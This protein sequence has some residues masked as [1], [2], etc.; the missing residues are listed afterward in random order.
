M[1]NQ[2]RPLCDYNTSDINTS[3]C[4][5][6]MEVGCKS[7]SAQCNEFCWFNFFAHL[8]FMISAS[9]SALH[10]SLQFSISPSLHVVISLKITKSS[11]GRF[12][13][14]NRD[15]PLPPPSAASL[16][17]FTAEYPHPHTNSHCINTSHILRNT[18]SINFMHGMEI[19]LCVYLKVSINV[20]WL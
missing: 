2:T 9:A 13:S 5:S 15:L 8:I 12:S 19:L 18:A 6:A 1:I 17:G 11:S 16:S 20:W 14:N 4:L 3:G 10:T 7:Q